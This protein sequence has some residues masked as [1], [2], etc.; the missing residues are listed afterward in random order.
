MAM[1]VYAQD[2][3]RQSLSLNLNKVDYTF[4]V[5]VPDGWSVSQKVSR[6]SHTLVNVRAGDTSTPSAYVQIFVQPRLNHS[7]AMNQL[8]GVAAN[9]RK[10]E[11]EFMQVGGWPAMQVTRV[12][13]PP[14]PDNAPVLEHSELLRVTTYIAA[15]GTLYTVSGNVPTNAAPDLIQQLKDVSSSLDFATSGAPKDVQS[16]LDQLR[17][18][19]SPSSLPVS[20]K[21]PTSVSLETTPVDITAEMGA[22]DRINTSGNGELEIATSPD[23]QNVVVALQSR[24]WV[25][26]ND[27]GATFPNSGRVGAG[28][29]DPSIAWGQSG[30][31][32]MAWIDTTATCSS[33]YRDPVVVPPTATLG[34]D[35][36]GMARSDDN[37]VTFLP[38]LV[39]PAVVCPTRAPAG[40]PDIPNECFP[41]QEHIA[42]DRW[43]PGDTANDDQVYST[44]RNFDPTDQN[45]AL[46]CSSD[47]GVT[48]TAPFDIQ[49]NDVFPRIT[50]GSDGFVYVATINTGDGNF[51]VHKFTS[52]V[53][54]LTEVPGWPRIVTAWNG[55][56]CPFA[57]HDRCDQNPTSQ[58]VIVDDTDPNHIYFAVVVNTEAAATDTGFSDII[59]FDSL[60]G[61]FTWNGIGR[62]ARANENVDARRVMPWLCATGGDA[63][64]TWYEQRMSAPT[65]TTDYYGA[66]LGLDS[67]GD[68]VPMEEF[69]LSEVP[70]NW[71]DIG[72]PG[73]TRW[74]NTDT[75]YSNAAEA[76]PNQPQLAGQCGDGDSPNVTPDS[77]IRCDF[78]DDDGITFTNCLNPG[79][80]GNPELCLR[81]GGSPKYG[82]YNGNACA[83][84]KLFS[85][86]ASANAPDGLPPPDTAN[87]PGVLFEVINL[88]DLGVPVITV[89]GNVHFGDTCTGDG[90]LYQD[91]QVCNTGS[92]DLQVDVITSDNADFAVTVP[93]SGY[94][95]TISPDFCFPFEVAYT[96]TGE[97]STAILTIPSDDPDR[98]TIEVTADASVGEANLVTIMDT[99]YGDICL[100]DVNTQQLTILND[101]A[102]DLIVS[103]AAITSGSSEFEFATV[104]SFPF[105]LQNGESVSAD[106]EFSPTGDVG[107]A[108]GELTIDSDDPDTPSEV[109]DLTGNSPQ[110]VISTFIADSG[111]FSN[112]CAD[113]IKDINLTVENNG[114]CPLELDLVSI[115]LG[116]NAQPGDFV[117]PSGNNDGTVIA[118][119]SSL[120]IPVRFSPTA[121][122]NEPPLTRDATVDITSHTYL[123]SSSLAPVSTPVNGVVP[124]PDINLAIANDGNFGNVCKNGF[125]DLDLTLFNQGMCDLEISNIELVPPGGSFI[126]PSDI[127]LPLVLSPDADFNYPIRYAPVV[128]NDVPEVAQVKVTSDDP[129]EMMEFVDISG[130]SP[131]PNLVIDPTGLT[132]DFAFPATVTDLDGSLGCYS[133]RTTVLRNSGLCPLTIDSITA[134]SVDEFTVQSPS[135]F[136]IVLPSGEET[137]DVTVRFTPQ[138]LGDPLAPDEFT[139]LLTVVSDDP[140]GNGLA[141]LCGEGVAQSGIRVLTTDI[142]SGLPL[143]VDSVDNITIRS[144]GKKTPSPINLQFTDVVPQSANICGNTVTWHVDQETLPAVDTTGS[145]PKSSYQASAKEGSL[146]AAESFSLGQCEFRDFQ[147]QL[148]D[149]VSETCLL[150]Q[151][152]ESCTS[153][154]QCCSGKCKGPAGNQTCK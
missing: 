98:P 95:V 82:D 51:Y 50:V 29:G 115:A 135:V 46:V 45:A 127:D 9:I 16:E 150:L 66:R 153:A 86:W 37:G 57:G 32:Y 151:K 30:K 52:C 108:A 88:S 47:S 134:S 101:G 56:R 80:S 84:G 28:N 48:W 79:P 20:D 24:R 111:A 97:P 83:G 119:A 99:D 65:D 118:P 126:L 113:D 103:D 90:P 21:S 55:Y 39:N 3:S 148:L 15:G 92:A 41:D 145:N 147:L 35:C 72:W 2:M 114:A 137:L 122:D 60:D 27:G 121:F 104:I 123:A 154:G 22:N 105:T 59:V 125:A 110:A 62:V 140:D 33:G 74:G 70:D 129:D 112:V 23:G 152:G 31:F 142:S 100:G 81:G 11:K 73:L 117:I 26:S 61:G 120:Q 14:K 139:G 18:V 138:S 44:W 143:V 128:C 85:A 136:P 146:Q 8:Q 4:D 107:A 133:E 93:S 87:N 96:P 149:S 6:N 76:C 64:V 141:D 124:P 144:K 49:N 89:P 132:G 130:T 54:G 36:T 19:E 69:V 67:G 71:C 106:I 58:T 34:I 7:D 116:A 40:Q 94:P 68:L 25:S 38:S 13:S 63:V 43:N 91:L 17:A 53:N 77:G 109:L 42:A 75:Q 1:S 10:E 78:S 5:G 131:C 12:I 102:C